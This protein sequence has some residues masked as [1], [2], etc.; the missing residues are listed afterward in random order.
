MTTSFL[1]LDT[2]SPIT[3]TTTTTTTAAA[4]AAVACTD[5]YVDDVV[6]NYHD[7]DDRNCTCS[8]SSN[9]SSSSSNSPPIPTSKGSPSKKRQQQRQRQRLTIDEAITLLASGREGGNTTNIGQEE[10]DDS[11]DKGSHSSSTSFGSSSSSSSDG[12]GSGSGSRSSRSTGRFHRRL[13]WAVGMCNGVNA[14]VVMVISFLHQTIMVQWDLSSHAASFLSSSV[15]VGIMAGTFILGPLG[16]TVGRKPVFMISSII[17]TVCGMLSAAAPD[18]YILILLRF[19]V[20]FGV[21]GTVIPFDTLAEFCSCQNRGTSLL[22]LGYF[23]TVGTSATP[24][25][26]YIAFQQAQSWRLLLLMTSIPSIFSTIFGW[27][28][29]PESPRWLLEDGQHD[30]ALQVLRRAAKDNGQDPN[31]LFPEPY[32]ELV[33]EN[34]DDDDDDEINDD[35]GIA[36]A[37]ALAAYRSLKNQPCSFTDEDHNNN[38]DDENRDFTEPTDFINNNADH[39]NNNNN[40]KLH[41]PNASIFQKLFHGQWT[42]TLLCFFGVWLFLDLIYW[43]TIQVVTL[44][45]ADFDGAIDNVEDLED[46]AEFNYDYLAIFSTSLAEIVGQTVVLMLVDRVGRILTQTI[47]YLMGGMC[48]LALCVVAH[49]ED[50]TGMPANRTTLVILSFLARMCIMGATSVTWVHAAELLPTSIRNTAHAIAD[51]LAGLGG[52]S[53]PWLVRPSNSKLL[54]GITMAS[55]CTI[56]SILTWM[57]PETMGIALGKAMSQ[58]SNLNKSQSQKRKGHFI[59]S[60]REDGSHSFSSTTEL[61]LE[62]TSID[63]LT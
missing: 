7:N 33:L 53:S 5:H 38:N 24:L 4:A 6:N 17:V 54:T 41:H 62:M 26:A 50:V 2:V 56:V 35:G 11:N 32:T 59:L 20:G 19:C 51:A 46:G 8:S 23:W 27:L 37:A 45:F 63:R 18:Y 40:N 57:L 39:N 30:A 14:M 60:S 10:D 12:S 3:I 13:L 1:T 15:F 61:D 43:G 34:D 58:K 21:G 25:L 22:Y 28:W 36:A 29:V 9:S 44:A 42:R 55:I 16:D 47:P 49:E 52:I 48:V 31:Q